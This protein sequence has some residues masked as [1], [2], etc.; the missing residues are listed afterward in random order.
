MNRIIFVFGLLV[1]GLYLNAQCPP[2]K[3]AFDL[4]WEVYL[5]NPNTSDV[6]IKNKFNQRAKSHWPHLCVRGLLLD[7]PRIG[8]IRPGGD[9]K[10]IFVPIRAPGE[11]RL[12]I[13]HLSGSAPA[14]FSLLGISEG[15]DGLVPRRHVRFNREDLVRGAGESLSFSMTLDGDGTGLHGEVVGLVIKTDEAGDHFKYRI[16]LHKVE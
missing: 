7:K 4:M 11:Y 9:Q 15:G 16:L 1:I 6:K 5:S 10:R 14:S 13:V 2:A 8:M 12:E 3:P